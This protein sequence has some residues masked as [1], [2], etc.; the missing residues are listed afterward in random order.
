MTRT[1]EEATKGTEGGQTAGSAGGEGFSAW[2]DVSQTYALVSRALER[3]IRE[4]FGLPLAGYDVLAQLAKVPEGERVRMQELARRVLLSKSGLSQ[5]F[6]RL[7]AR[8]LVERRG[9]PENLRVTHAGITAEGRIMLERALPAFHAEV[10]ERFVRHLDEEEIRT[11]RRTMRK[12]IRA[13]GE[14]PLSGE[15]GAATGQDPS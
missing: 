8:G 4:Q 1:E 6:S 15:P 3:T 7:E 2:S 9:D 5:L 10:A 13:S 11:L 12:L 14:E